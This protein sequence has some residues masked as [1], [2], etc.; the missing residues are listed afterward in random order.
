[1]RK[2]VIAITGASGSV[3]AKGILEKLSALKEHWNELGII[4]SANAQLGMAN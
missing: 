2:I 3:Y 4:M 1:M